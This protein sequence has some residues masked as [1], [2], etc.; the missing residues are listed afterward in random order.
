[1]DYIKG[2]TF[3]WGC[4]RGE[5]Q[6]K[7][8]KQSLVLLKERTNCN[9]IIIA[10]AA[11]QDTAH[12]VDIDYKGEHI[13][14][15][16]EL[17]EMINYAKS[18]GLKVILK[19]TVNVK[20]GI[21]RAHINFFDIDV[22]FEPKW[23]EWFKSYTEYQLHYAKIAEKTNCEMVIVGCEMVQT[24]RRE[25][26]WRKLIK[27]VR[28][29]YKGLVSYNCDKYQENTVNW[30]DEVDVISSSGYYPISDWDT[31]LERIKK[32]VN[33]YKKPFFFAEAGCQSKSGASKIP[34]K[35]DL[36]GEIDFKEQEDYYKVMFEKVNNEK[37][38]NGFGLWEWP[39]II[40]SENNAHKNKCYSIYGKP[41][42]KIV[43]EFYLD[44]KGS[45]YD[46]K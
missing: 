42:E 12:S 19:P 8:V 1:M 4:R 40:Y 14:G 44:R 41:A 27:D 11:L 6:K 46:N 29:I 43:R 20:N 39:G 9:Y 38:I 24:T 31:Q 23:S 7:G 37:W 28:K 25:S 3:G 5:F 13:V 34:N 22:P 35:W 45:N 30:W 33:E 2:I 36:E 15:D 32:V 10:I 16:L 26:E 18:M 17:I 21:W